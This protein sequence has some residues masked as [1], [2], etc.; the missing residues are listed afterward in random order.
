MFLESIKRNKIAWLVAA[1][2]AIAGAY[3][4]LGPKAHAADKGGIVT[5]AE[6]EQMFPTN[7]WT[8]VY[9]SAGIVTG[10]LTSDFGVGVDGWGVSGRVGA[11]VQ[12]A[13]LLIGFLGD[14]Q[15][16]H[17]NLAGANLSAKEYGGAARAGFL[18]TENVLIYGL[19]GEKW[20]SVAGANTQGLWTGGGVEVAVTKNWRLGMEYGHQTWDAIPA[21][22]EQTVQGRLIFAFP[23]K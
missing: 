21:A 2:V 20:L 17:V 10:S 8:A 13:K 19:V 15:W 11:D 3:L 23:V 12:I 9:A 18:A 4:F 14:F 16:D 6:A 5:R 7:P 22:R 1:L